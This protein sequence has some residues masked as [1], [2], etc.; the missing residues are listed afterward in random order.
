MA[1]VNVEDMYGSVEIVVFPRT[2]LKEQD[3]L[4]EDNALIIQGN[5]QVK[6]N[7]VSIIADELVSIEKAEET[8]S[9]AVH[10]HIDPVISKPEISEQLMAVIQKYPGDCKMYAHLTIPEKTETII[11]FPDNCRIN[12]NQSFSAELKAI[13]GHT[14]VET[15]C[16][17]IKLSEER[18][19][20]Q[21]FKKKA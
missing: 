17:S 2:F 8:W 5:V 6:E 11:E 18:N 9:A 20:K 14:N 13:V 10:V 7:G 4:I 15:T 3:K 16:K 19:K 21:F 12:A 1:F